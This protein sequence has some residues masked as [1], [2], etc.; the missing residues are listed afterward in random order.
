[1]PQA[2]R[3]RSSTPLRKSDT[4]SAVDSIRRIVRVLRLA[5]QKTQ[6]SAGISAAQLFVLQRLGDGEELSVNELARRTLTDRSSVA[7]L[8][9]RLQDQ[10]FVDRST[11]PAD[12]RRAVVRITGAGR[13]LLAKAPDAPTTTLLAALRR[14]DRRELT[15]LAR[16]LRGLSRALGAAEEPASML[17][18]EDAGAR[19][20]RRGA[21]TRVRTT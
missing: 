5:A 17:F 11:H 10:Q 16:S 15:M 1:M 20:P 21:R 19:A 9:E 12:R 6:T 7:A 8:V 18:A 13:R 3:S 4:S 2:K 14:L